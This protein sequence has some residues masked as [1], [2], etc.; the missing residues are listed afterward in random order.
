MITTRGTPESAQDYCIGKI[1]HFEE[2]ADHNKREALSLFA[3]LI[4]CTLASP[5]LI[6]LGPGVLLG[7]IAPSVLSSVAAGCAVWLQQRKPQ[8]LWTLYRTTQRRLEYEDVSF[9]FLINDYER[10][11]D[12]G[13][14]LAQKTATI[15]INANELWTPLIPNPENAIGTLQPTGQENKTAKLPADL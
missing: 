11:N 5:L 4:F 12:P 9:R 10:A 14:M 13:K 6:T 8:Q 2:K 7:K 1:R 15:C 3:T